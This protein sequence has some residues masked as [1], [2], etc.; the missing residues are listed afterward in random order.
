M[1]QRRKGKHRPNNLYGFSSRFFHKKSG[2]PCILE[3][4]VEK[5]DFKHLKADDVDEVSRLEVTYKVL[6]EQLREHQARLIKKKEEAIEEEE[7]RK[8]RMMK[9]KSLKETVDLQAF[10][11]HIRHYEN[12]GSDRT[13]SPDIKR[14]VK[15]LMCQEHS[16]M[17]CPK[18][19]NYE[20]NT[21][22][23]IENIQKFMKF[24]RE[25]QEKLAI[26]KRRASA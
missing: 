5:D 14:L 3:I 21:L 15:N 7:E 19:K 17:Y 22:N 10:A 12:Y 13:V 6:K 18:C 4:E 16:F 23:P 9:G 25:E 26:Q 20:Q 2:N 24:V 11:K 1:P 8:L